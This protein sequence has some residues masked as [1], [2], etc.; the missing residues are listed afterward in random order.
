MISGQ[1]T[2]QTILSV[3]SRSFANRL[4]TRNSPGIAKVPGDYP[5]VKGFVATVQHLR[6]ASHIRAVYDSHTHHGVEAGGDN[7]GTPNQP[8]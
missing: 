6:K 2:Y 8:L 3:I 1:H 4:I 7:S 5:R